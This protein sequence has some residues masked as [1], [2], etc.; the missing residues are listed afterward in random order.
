[1]NCSSLNCIEKEQQM[2]KLATLRTMIRI[3]FRRLIVIS[4]I[5]MSGGRLE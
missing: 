4:G 2:K 1:M 3:V 5:D